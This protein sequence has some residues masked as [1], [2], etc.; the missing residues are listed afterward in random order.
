M[1]TTQEIQQLRII[2]LHWGITFQEE[3]L[4]PLEARI[5]G[6]FTCPYKEVCKLYDFDCHDEYIMCEKYKFFECRR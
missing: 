5:L 6:D 4:A 3:Q 1:T 2:P